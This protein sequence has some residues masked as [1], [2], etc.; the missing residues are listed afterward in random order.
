MKFENKGLVILLCVLVVAI[1][2]LVVGIV[3]P[4]GGG[5]EI[6]VVD[7]PSEEQV[8]RDEYIA[9]VSSY[10]DMQVRVQELL[11]EEP[12]DVEEIRKL[13]SEQIDKYIGEENY[14]RANAFISAER[15][16]LLSKGLERAA[17]DAMLE[18]D[19]SSFPEPAQ[20]RNYAEIVRLAEGLGNAT[21]AAEYQGLAGG[22]KEAY[23]ANYAASEKVKEESE[24][25]RAESKQDNN[26]G[27]DIK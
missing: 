20:Y 5:E 11:N 14:G 19:F 15:E 6:V 25:S 8:L 1:V 21:V 24:R 27:E 7:E 17:L 10:D 23:E 12:I 13:Y 9:Y 16:A 2:G 3:L 22:V 4:K 26:D 18:I